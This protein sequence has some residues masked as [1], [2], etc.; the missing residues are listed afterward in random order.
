MDKPDEGLSS[1]TS[2]TPAA[3]APPESPAPPTIADQYAIDEDIAEAPGESPEVPSSMPGAA[4]A[5]PPPVSS[6]THPAK[7][8]QMALDY[9]FSDQ[10]IAARPTDQLAEAVYHVQKKT[11]EMARQLS[12]E[13]ETTRATERPPSP[14]PP[15]PPPEEEGLGLDETQYD[16]GLMGVI[17]QQRSELKALRERLD[18]NERREQARANEGVAE[19]VDRAFG[20]H[21]AVLG[22]GRRQELNKDS[23]EY[24][25][26]LAVLGMVDRDTSHRSLEEKID[27]AVEVLYG[28]QAPAPALTRQQQRWAEG[29]VARPTSR[30][31]EQEPPGVKK[32]RRA[33]AEQLAQL[34]RGGESPDNGEATADDF[35]GG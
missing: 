27:R 18:F 10:E 4:P 33:V 16:P 2:P 35:L 15:E 19:R 32:A 5:P 24:A 29:G 34:G 23:A 9:G 21:E 13:R 14:A 30:A 8:A 28:T 31:A 3:E 17:K 25:R 22:K 11:L 26:R 1:A 20:R 7:L 6:H 12:A